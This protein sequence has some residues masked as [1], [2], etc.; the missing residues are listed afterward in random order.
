MQ[1]NSEIILQASKETDI[2]VTVDETE[3]MNMTQ[4]QYQQQNH[5]VCNK[6]FENVSEFK[7]SPA[8]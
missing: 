6:S 2:E 3:C 5:N 1:N 4:N 8:I 7:C